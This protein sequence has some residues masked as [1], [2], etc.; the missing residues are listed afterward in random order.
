MSLLTN[1]IYFKKT[2]LLL[3]V[4]LF[5]LGCRKEKNKIGLDD[6]SR[7]SSNTYFTDTVTVKSQIVLINDSINTTNVNVGGQ[8]LLLAG[9]YSDP[10]IGK[11]AAE[12]YTRLRLATEFVELPAATADS[13]FLYLHY[14]YYYGNITQSQ[15]LNVYKL[16]STISSDVTYFS[17]SAGINYDPT[18]IGIINFVASSDTNSQ[19]KI[20]IT[21]IAYLQSILAASKN[22]TGFESEIKGLAIVPSNNSSGAI[23]RINGNSTG[24]LFQIYYTQYAQSKV[25]ALTL[26]NTSRKFYRITTDRSGTDLAS[27]VNNYDSI[28]T[29]ALPSNSNRC[30]LQACSGLRT[31]LSFPYLKNLRTSFPNIS[32]VKGELLIKPSST[33]NSET[34]APNPGLVLIR[35][36]NGKMKRT[37]AGGIY[38]V[39]PDD[40]SQTGNGFY[41]ITSYSNSQYSFQFRSYAQAVLLNQLENNPVI[42]SPASLST[43]ANRL[44]FNDYNNTTNPV[45]LNLYFITTK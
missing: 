27:L 42:V 24:S 41:S 45:K 11:T 29:N 23:I 34:Y 40:V 2:G 31:R 5:F 12:S 9:A 14:S 15:T 10:L 18:P 38:Y 35:T 7:I 6:P 1:R 19:L 25:Y 20:K 21:N 36:E 32:I 4:I 33:S 13:G 16:T 3:L 22:N 28:N 26:T 37:A 8:S 43:E 17:N 30:Y 44:V 39:Q